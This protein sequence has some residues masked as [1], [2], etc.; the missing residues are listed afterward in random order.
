[1]NCQAFD[2]RTIAQE[3]LVVL[4]GQHYNLERLD[5]EAGVVVSSLSL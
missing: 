4:D 5:L 2:K 1:M 3:L